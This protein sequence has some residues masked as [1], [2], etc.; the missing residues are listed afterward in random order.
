MD[1]L[2]EQANGNIEII[3]NALGIEHDV[4]RN[5]IKSGDRILRID[6][7]PTES[8]GLRIPDGNE[9]GSNQHWIPGGWTKGGYEEAVVDPIKVNYHATELNLK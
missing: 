8:S 5:Q 4:W 3:E 9:I 7:T 6:F 2:L 1:Q